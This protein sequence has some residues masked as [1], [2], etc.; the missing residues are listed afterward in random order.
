MPCSAGAD[1]V[2]LVAAKAAGLVA[3]GAASPVAAFSAAGG[4]QTRKAHAIISL[5]DCILPQQIHPP[6]STSLFS[7][8]SG[9][10]LKETA[11]TRG[12]HKPFLENFH[13]N[14]A[15]LLSVRLKKKPETVH[16][17]LGL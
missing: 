14:F 13:T 8:S 7:R 2:A 3:D 17:T 4:T 1:G 6:N 10:K 9:R 15:R 12:N 16:S 11:E 5:S